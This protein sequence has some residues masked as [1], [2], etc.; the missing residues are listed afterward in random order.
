MTRLPVARDSMFGPRN[1]PYG[2]YSL[3]GGARRVATRLGGNVID[4]GELLGDSGVNTVFSEPSLNGFMA[5][6]HR[7]WSDVRARLQEAVAGEITDDAVHPLA[8]VALHLPFEVADYVD[9]YASEHHAANLGRLFRPESADPLTPNWKQLPIGY[10]GRSASIV[11]SGTSI[12]RRAS[13]PSV[14]ECFPFVNMSAEQRVKPET[15]ILGI[16]SDSS[17]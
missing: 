4:L 2:V 15:G 12:V 8:A 5:Q 6:G 10:H 9:F 1:L 7:G 3:P 11:V 13:K 17:T 16:C 14:L